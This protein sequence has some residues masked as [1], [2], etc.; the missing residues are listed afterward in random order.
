MAILAKAK[1]GRDYRLT[2][3]QEVRGFMELSE[4]DEIVFYSVAGQRGRVCFRRSSG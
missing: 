4:G 3:P 1:I 2:L